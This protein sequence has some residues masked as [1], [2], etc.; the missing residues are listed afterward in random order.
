MPKP[1]HIVG[2]RSVLCTVRC[3]LLT[4]RRSPSEVLLHCRQSSGLRPLLALRTPSL[5]ASH[6]LARPPPPALPVARA[7]TPSV[8]PEEHPRPTRL[9]FLRV[10]FPV[11]FPPVLPLPLPLLLLLLQQ[12]Q[13]QSACCISASAA[14]AAARMPSSGALL[15]SASTPPRRPPR[16]KNHPRPPLVRGDRGDL[17]LLLEPEPCF[18]RVC[19]RPDGVLAGREMMSGSS[20]PC[21]DPFCLNDL[22]IPFIFALSLLGIRP[23]GVRDGLEIRSGSS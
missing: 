23:N 5:P 4:T 6:T 16:P 3:S 8:N 20:N 14:A 18:W 9:V 11:V 21:P 15:P 1:K 10:L 7:P 17:I 19:V 22:S 2:L 13:Q 12:Q